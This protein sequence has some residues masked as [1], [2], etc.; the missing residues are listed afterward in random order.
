MSIFGMVF[1]S[2]GVF[3]RVGGG[4]GIFYTGLVLIMCIFGKVAAGHG[5]FCQGWCWSWYIF[6][7]AGYGVFLT[8]SL[9]FT[10]YI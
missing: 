6:D 3:G 9:Q 2:W 1:T 8:G 7:W 5:I 4:Y 10:G